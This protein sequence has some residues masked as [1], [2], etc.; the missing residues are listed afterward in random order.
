MRNFKQHKSQK[1]RRK[2]F[3]ERK[4]SLPKEKALRRELC[5][6]LNSISPGAAQEGI[7]GAERKKSLPKERALRRELCGTLNKKGGC[8]N[9][10]TWYST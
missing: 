10:S 9:E 8:G 4:K 2:G 6:T 3:V 7:Y 1:Q 5:G